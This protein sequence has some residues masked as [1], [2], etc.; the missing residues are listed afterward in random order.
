MSFSELYI[1]IVRTL[2]QLMQSAAIK[3]AG[4]FVFAVFA[5]MHTQLL[6]GFAF[7]VLLDLFTKW[8]ALSRERLL[9]YRRKKPPTFY[10]CVIGIWKARKAG[11]IKSS[12]MKHRFVGKIIVYMVIAITGATFDKMM[13]DMGS[14]PWAT[15]LLIGYLAITELMSIVENLEEAGV[16]AAGDLHG[17]LEKKMEGLK[18]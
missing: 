11:Y 12:E 7:L 6:L 2:H 3:T 13:G 9:K 10:E 17:I 5:H 14:S 16:D 15:V 4:S 8:A 18:K 1:A